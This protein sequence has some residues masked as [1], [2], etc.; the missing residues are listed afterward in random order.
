MIKAEALS[1]I[2]DSPLPW[3][4]G[5]VSKMRKLQVSS[6]SASFPLETVLRSV[7]C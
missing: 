7:I 2:V 3:D 1:G 6:L 4:G 5:R